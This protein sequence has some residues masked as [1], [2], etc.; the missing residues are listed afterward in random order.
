MFLLRFLK[1]MHLGLLPVILSES[2]IRTSFRDSFRECFRNSFRDFPGV[3]SKTHPDNPS[4]IPLAVHLMVSPESRIPGIGS[5]ISPGVFTCYSRRNYCSYSRN[6]FMISFRAFIRN[7][8]WNLSKN[9]SWYLFPDSSR[10]SF[11]NF[12][13]SFVFIASRTPC[14]IF[15]DLSS[16]SIRDLTKNSELNS[17]RDCSWKCLQE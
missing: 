15:Q 16:R 11:C 1:R 6:S 7:F 3:L 13:R 12:S 8:F 5:W 4:G 9:F 14:A 10:S 17:S 2:R